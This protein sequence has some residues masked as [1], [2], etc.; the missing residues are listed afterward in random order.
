MAVEGSFYIGSKSFDDSQTEKV[1]NFESSNSISIYIYIY[2][3]I[4]NPPTHVF[5]AVKVGRLFTIRLTNTIYT[6]NAITFTPIQNPF[7]QHTAVML[8]KRYTVMLMKR[9]MKIYM[10]I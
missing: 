4:E 6:A 2:I 7:V 9:Y 8:M 3:Y 5:L 10:K 1:L